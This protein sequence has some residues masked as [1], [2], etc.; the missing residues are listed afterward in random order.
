MEKSI[1]KTL[2]VVKNRAMGDSIMTL[3]T[4]HYLKDIMPETK[5][6]YGVPK[7]IA[8][9]YENV[10]THAD[11]IIPL[12][13]SSLTHWWEMKKLLGSHKI[14]TVLEL[15]QSGRTAKFFK[16][17]SRLGGPR[18]VAHN[19][20]TSH[21]PVHDQGKIK[22]NIQRDLDAA[23]TF[24]GKGTQPPHFLGYPPKVKVHSNTPKDNT[25]IL[26]VVATRPTK[27]W[28]LENYG[29][30]T[31]LLSD[32]GKEIIIPLGPGDNEI[33]NIIAPLVSENTKF[34]KASLD[35][36]PLELAGCER[37]IGNDTG[38]KHICV[39]LGIPTFTLFGPEP[40]TEWHPY[41]PILHPY[42]FREPLEC[43]TKIAHYCGL[44]TCESMI[45]L[46]EFGPKEV[47]K[48]VFNF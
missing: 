43:R 6:L 23:W 48:R 35:K 25:I 11:E 20:H 22:S 14:D 4:L 19:H 47:L 12:D 46:N 5:I 21:G 41:D 44:H 42:Y 17:W 28:P 29:K 8:P 30:L 16:L 34:I 3:S 18:Y 9:L 27:M 39:A 15:F 31:H 45:C 32:Q 26:G 40:P 37:Y 2:L 13:F 10:E 38:L 33:E 36:L 1:P 24:F 7:W